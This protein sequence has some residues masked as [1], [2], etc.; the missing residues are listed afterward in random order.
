MAVLDWRDRSLWAVGTSYVA[1]RLLLVSAVSPAINPD[2]ASYQEPPSFTGQHSR[3]WVVPLVQY[4]LTERQVVIAQALL[5]AFAFVMLACALAG[6]LHDHRARVAAMAV[7]LLLGIA[8]RVTYWDA[9]MLSESI[10]VSLTALLI[11]ALVWIDRLR[12]VVVVTIFALWLFT[13]DG[14]LYLG[15][16]LLVGLAWWGWR[17]RRLTVPIGVLAMLAWGFVA[18]GNNSTIE[19]YNVSANVAYRV[20]PN[21]G[22]WA[23]FLDQGMPDSA[24]FAD[25]QPFERNSN[26]TRDPTFWHWSTTVGPHIYLEFLLEHPR[27]TFAA[28]PHVFTGSGIVGESLVDHTRSRMLETPGPNFVWPQQASRYT[29][30]VTWAACLTACGLWWARRLDRRWLLPGALIASTVPHALLAYHASPYDIA[31]HG[32]VLSLVL[33]VASWWCIALGADALLSRSRE[34][35]M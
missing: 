33:V 22:E 17:N 28:L 30:I 13:R 21:H 10:A 25:A 29:F 35:S 19:G 27:Y 6:T 34:P 9:M 23:W 16:L 12:P 3:P 11:A 1:T 8:P 15:V 26:L 20:T 7:V 31:R 4:L 18:A 32:V 5:G 24:A 14:H 2:T